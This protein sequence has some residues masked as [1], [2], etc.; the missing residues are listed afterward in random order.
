MVERMF[1]SEKNDDLEKKFER[2]FERLSDKLERLGQPKEGNWDK[3]LDTLGKVYDR[4][5]AQNQGANPY[6][7]AQNLLTMT[8]EQ[9][10]IAKGSTNEYDLKHLEMQQ[11]GQLENQKL[12]WEIEKYR[13]SKQS[14]AD[15][16]N[17]IKDIFK[18]VSSGPIGKLISGAGEGVKNRIAGGPRIPTTDV[19]CPKCQNKFR[20]SPD[21]LMVT[22]P[23]C[24]STL[25]KQEQPQP[26]PSQPE[27]EATQQPST[28]EPKPEPVTRE[29]PIDE[30]ASMEV[31]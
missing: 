6:Q 23:I 17:A 29:K 8:R 16:I 31:K 10:N 15:T 3:A 26:Q 5:S 2:Q 7:I 27:P 18:E 25:Q 19:L 24:G 30:T 13:D 1:P 14:S 21:L 4:A 28:E 9:A 12:A 11:L 20:A 22:C